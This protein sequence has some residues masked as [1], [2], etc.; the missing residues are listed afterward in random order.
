MMDAAFER[1][2]KEFSCL[3]SQKGE[4]YA[5]LRVTSAGTSDFLI[6]RRSTRSTLFIEDDTLAEAVVQKMLEHG[7]PVC[8]D[9]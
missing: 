4:D 6:V 3:W 2:L 9:F 8:D 7:V 1:R 5:L